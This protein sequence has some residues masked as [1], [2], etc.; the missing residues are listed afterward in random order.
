M[1]EYGSKA[2]LEPLIGRLVALRVLLD[3][4]PAVRQREC[5]SSGTPTA[6]EGRCFPKSRRRRGSHQHGP[7][8]ETLIR[9]SEP[10]AQEQEE[11]GWKE[12]DHVRRAAFPCATAAST[13]PTKVS[14]SPMVVGSAT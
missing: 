2:C 1:P 8:A 12:Q 5:K 13:P 14:P 9:S 10:A 6:V 11:D 4:V 7:I 3:G